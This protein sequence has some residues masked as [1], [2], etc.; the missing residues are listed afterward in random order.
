MTAV[1]TDTPIKTSSPKM[2]ETLKGVPVSFRASSAPTGS[3]KTTL[4]TT[5]TGNLKLP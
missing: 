5:I 3:V 2:E 4:S 1:S